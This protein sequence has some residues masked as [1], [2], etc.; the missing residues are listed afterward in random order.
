MEFNPAKH[1]KAFLL[2]NF[3][4]LRRICKKSEAFA[5]DP[6]AQDIDILKLRGSNDI[7][8]AHILA[9][10]QSSWMHSAAAKIIS[11]LSL[12]SKEGFTV[13]HFLAQNQPE[14]IFTALAKDH[15]ILQ[16]KTKHGWSVAHELASCQSEWVNSEA[17]NNKNI[18]QLSS[19]NGS[20]VA[21]MVVC[22]QSQ[23]INAQ[24]EQLS[25]IEKPA[26]FHK[27]FLTI[28]EN[29]KLIAELI[30][31]RYSESN[32]L[33]IASM[34]I[35]L[36]TQGA[37]Y[38]HS[39]PLP[40][41]IGETLLKQT[42]ILIDD[43]FEPE[44][45]LRYAQAIYATMFHGVA[46]VEADSEQLD[47]DEWL[48]MLNKAETIIRGIVEKHPD[49]NDVENPVGSFCEPAYEFFHRLKAEIMFKEIK[50]FDLTSMEDDR[51]SSI[52]SGLY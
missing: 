29:G 50:T 11:V 7:S 21:H 33:D 49:V 14:W 48:K 15:Q 41:S 9:E 28:Q 13:A 36:I 1:T 27:D 8:V 6:L 31:D 34:A 52:K 38:K 4:I 40:A 24:S 47:L 32:G 20:T 18:M 3:D 12:E 10:H 23:W 19:D 46:K 37:A 26:L 42:E 5:M 44:I 45:A 30:S 39:K 43:C 51:K 35:L 17:I 22:Y 16:L 2:E 25:N